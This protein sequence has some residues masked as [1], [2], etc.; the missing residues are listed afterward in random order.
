MTDLPLSGQRFS[1]VNVKRGEP[2]QESARMRRRIASVIGTMPD[3]HD[4]THFDRGVEA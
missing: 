4:D 2:T 1:H 3:L